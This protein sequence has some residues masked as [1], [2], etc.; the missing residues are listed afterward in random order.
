MMRRS[1]KVVLS[2]LLSLVIGV[3]FTFL[4]FT[5]L[6]PIIEAGIYYPNLKAV[7]EKETVSVSKNIDGYL[8]SALDTFQAIIRK[9]FIKRAFLSRQIDSDIAERRLAFSQILQ[10]YPQLES[11][12]LIDRIG[13]HIHYSTLESDIASHSVTQITYKNLDQTDRFIADRLFNLKETLPRLIWDGDRQRVIFVL[14]IDDSEGK[15][16]GTALFSLKREALENEIFSSRGLI[17]RDFLILNDAGILIDTSGTIVFSQPSPGLSSLV[18]ECLNLWKNVSGNSVSQTLLKISDVPQGI[19][20]FSTGLD[21]VGRVGVLYPAR[22][23]EMGMF[24]KILIL[25]VFYVTI[26]LIILLVTNIKQDPIKIVAMRMHKFQVEFLNA[27]FEKKDKIDF[28]R[29]QKEMDTRRDEIKRYMKKG[30]KKISASKEA[31][32]DSYIIGSWNEVV[33]IIKSKVQQQPE[34]DLSRIEMLLRKVLEEGRV[35]IAPAAKRAIG[36]TEAVRTSL[37]EIRTESSATASTT[38]AGA[39]EEISELEELEEIETADK[40]GTTA[41]T[42]S[43]VAQMEEVDE[44][45][46]LEELPT[47]VAANEEE[48]GELEAL[49]EEPAASGA[50]AT[51]QSQSAASNMPM[52]SLTSSRTDASSEAQSSEQAKTEEEIEYLNVVSEIKELP[53]LPY[54]QLEELQTVDIDKKP[55]INLI[56]AFSVFGT[57]IKKGEINIFSIDDVLKKAEHAS[58][59][60]IMRNGVYTINE[61]LYSSGRPAQKQKG[62]KALAQSLLDRQHDSISSIDEL[63]GNKDILADA[64]R[65]QI[66]ENISL[67]KKNI[68]HERKIP[69]TRGGMDLDAYMESFAH[70]ITDKVMIYAIGELIKKV[71]AVSS[72][73]FADDG[74]LKV[75]MAIGVTS[76]SAHLFSFAKDETLYQEYFSKKCIILIKDVFKDQKI[77]TSRLSSDDVKFIRSAVF[78]PARIDHKD[79]YLFFGMAENEGIADMETFLK[80]INV[81]ISK[82]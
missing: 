61:T 15:A 18:T 42:T 36:T 37:P 16:A 64:E 78:F 68:P 56:D 59:N 5:R 52:A 74:G 23:F 13:R 71:K 66:Q 25:S 28:S 60:I 70:Q 50:A 81:I 43:D 58:P 46:A 48:I 47:E 65:K 9:D 30:L 62:L 29:W 31:E 35:F 1:V 57:C 54:E 72:I 67:S 22:R 8:K 76:R 4:S 20:L 41:T 19:T 33:S 44:I 6:F 63:Y 10:E 17:F 82:S 12:R 21:S 55:N 11:V 49:E 51:S 73:L 79:A 45:E 26:F 7:G 24:D 69:L 53:P 14:S 2:L 34:N 75:N 32:I 38:K 27:F 3:V 40:D 77:F 80:K 39:S